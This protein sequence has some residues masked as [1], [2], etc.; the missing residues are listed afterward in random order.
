M[1]IDC[2]RGSLAEQIDIGSSKR[3][4]LDL[5]EKKEIKYNAKPYKFKIPKLEYFNEIGGFDI[6][7]N[8]YTIILENYNNTHCLG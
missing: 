5:L 6:K 1:Y 4:K 7:N 3:E 2:N 8:E